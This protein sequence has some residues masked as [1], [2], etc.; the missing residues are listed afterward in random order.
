MDPKI[1]LQGL[2]TDGLPLDKVSSQLR[3]AAVRANRS[4]NVRA[5]RGVAR[6]VVSSL[7]RQG[8]LLQVQAEGQNGHDPLFAR[9]KDS[10]R[11]L[12]LSAVGLELSAPPMAKSR[13]ASTFQPP[14]E[15]PKP[16][17][18][19]SYN[20]DNMLQ[21]M[22]D[23]QNLK[24][25]APLS[26]EVENI[27]ISILELLQNLTPQFHLHILLFGDPPAESKQELVSFLPPKSNALPWVARRKKGQAV[28]ITSPA[29]LPF[30]MKAKR[31]HPAG[32]QSA[33][34]I[35]LFPPGDLAEETPSE[36]SEVGLLFL[37]AQKPWPTRAALRL[38]SKLSQFVT[39]RWDVTNQINEKIQIDALTGLFNR[40][41][42][43]DHLPL[44]VERAKRTTTKLA[45]V[46]ADIDLFKAVN[47]EYG[48]IIGDEVLQ[49]VARRLKEEVRKV[50][51]V[52]RRGGEEFAL[53]LP[54]TGYKAV[55]EVITRLLD[56]PF[57][58]ETIHE[59]K[60]TQISIKLS[61]GVSIY[62]DT[63]VN[64]DQLHSQAEQLMFLSKDKGRNRCHYWSMDGAHLQQLPSIKNPG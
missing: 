37:V 5:M 20:L 2:L 30:A 21:A 18:S 28:S 43:D 15:K 25:G 62:P 33:Y 29:D 38:G 41:F 55:Q 61:F 4:G 60:P 45:M 50:D 64:D 42:L 49:M 63:A 51:V 24:V 58:L 35:P 10:S 59:G 8:D 46:V 13:G 1:E 11:L 57:L 44:L 22:R 7:F 26:G 53:I 39:H 40:R 31:A 36:P 19:A 23:A 9:V 54:Q 47:T 56:A 52:C 17:S 32:L 34:A 3:Q 16:L 12:N 48:L 14:A 6:V 27:L